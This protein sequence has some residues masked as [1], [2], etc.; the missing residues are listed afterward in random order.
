GGLL[1]ARLVDQ[2]GEIVLIR[3]LESCVVL[4]CPAHRQLQGAAGV[5]ARRPR[6][7]MDRRLSPR[8][9]LEDGGPFA[10]QEGE[11]AHAIQRYCAA[12]IACATQ[13]PMFLEMSP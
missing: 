8:C 1:E 9:G 3:E 13:V 11:L 5:K 12:K 4:E 6:I 2:R 7:G 10:L